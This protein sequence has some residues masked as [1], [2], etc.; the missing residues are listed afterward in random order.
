MPFEIPDIKMYVSGALIR[1]PII[2]TGTA[3]TNA[4]GVARLYLTNTLTALGSNIFTNVYTWATD[5]E[6]S[7]PVNSRA[8]V[9]G[10]NYL[11]V[12]VSGF[13]F[14]GTMVLGIPVLGS[15]TSTP[16]AGATV[17]FIVIGD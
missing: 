1:T 17:R 2:F 5:V 14:T 15:V 12:T 7:T 11:E 4:S 6:T 9:S 8:M 10:V 3:V 13:T 16:I